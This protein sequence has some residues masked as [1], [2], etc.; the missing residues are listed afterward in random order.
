VDLE[1]VAEAVVFLR[2]IMPR[3]PVS[4]LFTV[5]GRAKQ[6]KT[7][8]FRE[9]FRHLEDTDDRFVVAPGDKGLVMA[10]FTLSEFDVVFKVIRD[11]FPEVKNVRREE[12]MAKYD[13]VFK[14]DRA[15]RLVD[16]QEFKRMRF[17]RER[18][19]PEVLDE[20][21]GECAM[22]VQ[23]EGDYVTVNHMYIER[24]M[25]PLNLFLR[26]ATREQGEQAVIEYGQA[27]RELAYNNIFAGDLLLKN[28]GVTR[29]GRVIFYDYDELCR[30]TDCRFRDVPE[31]E[32]YE[33]EMRAESWFYI[34]ENDV[35]PET[36]INF[37][38]F[39]PHLKQVFLEAHGDILEADWW[40]Q[41]Q[42]RISQ[43][44][45]VEVLPYHS[46]RVRV[47]SSL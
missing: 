39:D 4:E 8:R 47:A 13:L 43:G 40:R 46:H 16:A 3:K 9:I 7:E 37:L 1:R 12:V 24:K 23:L 30:V 36:F 25:V 28:F 20:L 21:L 42:E 6:G 38:G 34:A 15:G 27:I 31:A 17:P 19:A 29:N 11:R 33:D 41:L 5:L 18:F 32:T 26:S 45:V 44:E 14:H 22:T 2:A 10:C 35:F